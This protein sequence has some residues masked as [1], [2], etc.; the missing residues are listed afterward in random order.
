MRVLVRHASRFA[1]DIVSFLSEP[2]PPEQEY[3]SVAALRSALRRFAHATE[4]ITRAHGLTSQRYDLLVV[5][6]GTSQVSGPTI[7]ELAQRLSLAPHS[8]TELVMRAEDAGL[9]R[10]TE[11]ASDGRLTRVVLSREGDDRLSEAVAALRPERH[12]LLQLLAEVY[13]QA[14]ALTG[15]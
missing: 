14:R 15:A 7:S 5:I 9:V 6:R 4:L 8:V 11:D 1:R 12:R 10:R 3:E 13:A 2:L